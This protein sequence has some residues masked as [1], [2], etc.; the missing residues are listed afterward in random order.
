MK[1]LLTIA[2]VGLFALT[3]A[4]QDNTQTQTQLKAQDVE[5]L[6]TQIQAKIHA[7]LDALPAKVQ[8]Q[9]QAAK[10][11]MEQVRTQIASMKAEGN[12]KKE[13]DAALA[14]KRTQAQEQLR[15]CIES[16]DGIN[17]EVKAQV[18]K[19]KDEVQTRL[20]ERSGEMKMI[21]EGKPDGAGTGSGSGQG[22][23]GK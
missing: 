11:S 16:M 3:V 21:Q 5:Q 19:A 1:K 17:A 12:T 6:K 22:G 15:L 13:I 18:Q 2:T 7:D 23:S 14:Q 10:Q 4:A 8:E 20:R 9:V